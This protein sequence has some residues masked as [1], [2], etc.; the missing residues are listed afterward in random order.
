MSYNEPT[1][2]SIIAKKD[3]STRGRDLERES[4]ARLCLPIH[5]SNRDVLAS[6]Y[7]NFVRR[8]SSNMVWLVIKSLRGSI[9]L[10]PSTIGTLTNPKIHS[11]VGIRDVKFVS[12]SLAGIDVAVVVQ[13]E[14]VVWEVLTCTVDGPCNGRLTFKY[15]TD[16]ASGTTIQRIVLLEGSGIKG[17]IRGIRIY[18][19]VDKVSPVEA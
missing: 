11:V 2:I 14:E 7:S 10:C 1:R 8:A 3:L 16:P 9:A 17:G 4:T 6:R 19:R 18:G 15:A 5:H 13:S 12:T